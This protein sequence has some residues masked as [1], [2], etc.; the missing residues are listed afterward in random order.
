M[1]TTATAP[2]ITKA[3]RE[4][5]CTFVGCRRRMGTSDWCATNGRAL[6]GPHPRRQYVN[7]ST[8]AAAQN[9]LPLRAELLIDQ[10]LEVLRGLRAGEPSAVD[11]EGGCGIDAER[12]PLALIRLDGIE[13]LL[14]VEA[15]LELRDVHPGALGDLRHLVPQVVLGDL[16]LLRE[17]PVVHGPELVV[18]LLETALRC[19]RSVLGPGMDAGEG[20]VLVDEAHLVA[21][22]LQHLV[23]EGGV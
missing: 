16:A 22:I 23:L 10:L 3:R 18:A 6:A 5:D 19:D 17:E 4:R 21:V 13:R 20:E 7:T 15:L 12:R 9:G 2:T 8:P 14:A 11:E 1:P